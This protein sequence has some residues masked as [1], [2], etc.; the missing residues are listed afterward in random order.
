[1][2]K[3]GFIFALL[4]VVYAIAGRAI[5]FD[6]YASATVPVSGEIAAA[7]ITATTA[8]GATGV[9]TLGKAATYCGF[10]NTTPNE[11]QITIGGVKFKRMPAF[12][13][14]TFD[15]GSNSGYLKGGTVIGVFA[16]TGTPASGVI[17]AVCNPAL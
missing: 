1:M 11:L 9:L 2:K 16:S 6:P 8:T 14:R 17:E 10:E 4:V 7:S 3:I 13:F 5:A 12:S 15:I